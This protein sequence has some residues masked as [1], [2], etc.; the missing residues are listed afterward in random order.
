MMYERNN[1][2]KKKL[3]SKKSTRERYELSMREW[4]KRSKRE[5]YE[6][7]KELADSRIFIRDIII[8]FWNRSLR[9]N[10]SSTG[11]PFK[12]PNDDF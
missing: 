2:L 3:K 6:L 7:I 5:R 12:V 4:Y 8:G 11:G 10:V 9:E 1:N